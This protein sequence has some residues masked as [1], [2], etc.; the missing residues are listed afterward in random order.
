M[1]EIKKW[2]PSD[3]SLWVKN[4][5]YE[6]YSDVPNFELEITQNVINDAIKYVKSKKKKIYTIFIKLY[7]D[8]TFVIIGT[9]NDFYDGIL[10]GLYYHLNDTNAD[11]PWKSFNE[12]LGVKCKILAIYKA[13]IVGKQLKNIKDNLMKN[14]TDNKLLHGKEIIKSNKKTVLKELSPFDKYINVDLKNIPYYIYKI[15]LPYIHN[16]QNIHHHQM[17][18]H[19]QHNN[20]IYHT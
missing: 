13:I 7:N 10:S 12:V 18:G 16:F 2:E 17:M 5:E 20:N 1:D 9:T 8:T 14:N 6:I 11:S 4:E 15:H 3:S 19:H